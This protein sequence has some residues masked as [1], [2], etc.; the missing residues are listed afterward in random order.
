MSL[1]LKVHCNNCSKDS[2][3][4]GD[5]DVEI[6]CPFCESTDL[7]TEVVEDEDY[8]DDTLVRTHFF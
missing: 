4:S 2:I 7:T 1:I 5:I 6:F 3:V 8:E